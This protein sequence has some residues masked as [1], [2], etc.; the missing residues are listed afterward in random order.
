M[1]RVVFP[2]SKTGRIALILA[3]ITLLLSCLDIIL[4]LSLFAFFPYALC[5]VG[6]ILILSIVTIVLAR[7]AIRKSQ[8]SSILA[9]AALIAGIVFTAFATLVIAL[10]LFIVFYMLTHPIVGPFS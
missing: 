2:V 8:D 5:S 3:L 10:I 4:L 6:L 1:A 9:K 7:S